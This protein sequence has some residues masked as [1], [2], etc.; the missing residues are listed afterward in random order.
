MNPTVK[1]ELTSVT[2]WLG[3]LVVLIGNLLPYLTPDTLEAIGF[4]GPRVRQISTF[5]GLLL[6]VYRE[7]RKAAPISQPAPQPIE[8]N[9]N[10]QVTP[11]PAPPV[12][13]S[14]QP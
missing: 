10:A 6:I 8:G 9:A 1:N 14:V 3:G 7:K 11:A 13:P 2:N 5:I 12:P 4:T